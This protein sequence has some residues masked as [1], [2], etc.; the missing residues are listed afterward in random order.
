M[1]FS[2][3]RD[4]TVVLPSSETALSDELTLTDSPGGRVIIKDIQQDSPVARVG[5]LKKGDQLNAVTIHFDNLNSKEVGEILKY[6]EPYKT[7]LKLNTNDELRT[8]AYGYKRSYMGSNDQTYL[9]LY[10]SKIKPHLKLA[11]PSLEARSLI[12]NGMAPSIDG[13]S[14]KISSEFDTNL[15]AS[16]TIGLNT[17]SFDIN[18]PHG[19]IQMPDVKAS[20]PNV[21]SPRGAIKMPGMDFKGAGFEMPSAHL[22]GIESTS[23]KGGFDGN[24]PS[25]ELHAPKF[26]M[27]SPDLHGPN[28]SALDT[29]LNFKAPNVKD[30][31]LN[32]SSPNID[33]EAPNFQTSNIDVSA[34]KVGAGIRIPKFKKPAFSLTGNDPKGPELDLSIPGVKTDIKTPDMDLNGGVDL[35]DATGNWKMPKMPSFGL[36]GPKGPDVEF[37][38][39]LKAPG[40]QIDLSAPDIKGDIKGP[41]LDLKGPN[42]DINAPRVN[43]PDA[44]GTLK[45]PNIKMPSFGFSGPKGPG[46]DFDG[47]VKAP[48]VDV[49]SPNIKGNFQSPDI[50]L[51]LPKGELDANLPDAE[52]NG[53]KFKLPGVKW[54][55]NKLSLSGPDNGLKLPKGHV[56]LSAP[57]LTGDIKGPSLGLKGPNVDLNAPSVGIPD[58]KTKFKMPSLPMTSFGMSGPKV[59]DLNVDGSVKAPSIDMSA[60]NIKGNFESS[61]VDIKLPKGDLDINMPYGDIKKPKFKM[62]KFNMP[63]TNMSIPDTSL[64]LKAPTV[65]GDFDAKLKKPNLD[66]S[67]IKGPDM[68]LGGNLKIPDADISSPDLKAGFGSAGIGFQK[69]KIKADYDMPDM[70]LD[71]PDVKLKGKGIKKPS[72]NMSAGKISVPDG[73]LNLAAPNV[74]LA[75]PKLQGDFKGPNI[76]IKSPKIDGSGAEGKF[77]FPKF[78]KPNFTL[79]RKKPKLD[80]SVPNV[81]ADIK[82]P[83]VD[84][85]GG[86]DLPEAKGKWKAPS[87]HL[88][89]FGGFGPK[90]PDGDFD[91]SFKAPGVD[92]SAPNLKGNFESPDI[93]LKLPK[94]E[95]DTNLPDA[96]LN[97]GKFK[98]PGVKWPHNKLSLSGPDKDLK[99]PKGQID[100]SAPDIRGGIKG[101]GLDV[102]GPNIDLNAP[103]IDVPDAKARFKMPN[104]HMPSF[105]LAGPKAPG[106][107]G[108]VK[109][110]DIDVSGPKIKGNFEPPNV[111]LNIPKGDLDINMPSAEIKKPKFTMPNFSMPSAN[112]STPDTSL[113]LKAPVVTGDFDAKLNKPNLDIPRI[114]GPDM[115]FGGNLKIPDADVKAGFGTAG[116]DFKKPK[117]N[118]DYDMPDMNLDV[119]DV[120]LKGKG[121]KKPS[122]NMSAGKISAPDVDLNLAAPNVDLASPKLQ[123]DFKGPNIDLNAPK[124]DGIDADGNFKLPKLT[125]PA[126]SLSGNKPKVPDLNLSVPDVKADI[127]TP[128]MDLNGGVDL[129]EAKGKWKMPKL[130][131]PSFGVSGPKG[132]DVDFDGSIKTPG[133][134]VSAP[135]LKGNFDSPDVDLKFP[136]GK[137]DANLPETELTGGKFKLPGVNW[138][139]SKLSLSGP[140][141]ELNLPKGQVDFSAPDIKGDIKGPGLDLKGPNMDINAPS[142]NMPDA[143]GK[144][145]MPNLTMPSFGFSGPKGPGVDFDGSVKAPSVDVSAPNLKGNFESPNVDLKLPKGKI[146]ANLP[147]AELK[148]GKFKLPGVNWP[149]NKLPLSGPDN[150]L[151]LP[152]GQVDLSGPDIQGDIRGPSIDVKAPHLSVS[153]P[154]SK[155]QMPKVELPSIRMSGPKTPDLGVNSSVKMPSVDVAGPSIKGNYKSPDFGIDVPNVSPGNV[156]L[157][158]PTGNIKGGAGIDM[159]GLNKRNMQGANIGVK[160]TKFSVS[161]PNLNGG[162]REVGVDVNSPNPSAQLYSPK[163]KVSTD[164]NINMQNNFSRE[165]F[166]LRSSSASDLDDVTAQGK[167]NTN[168]QPR[169]SSSIN[170]NDPSVSKKNKFKLS[171]LF[172]FNHKSK[173]SVDFTKSQA[174]KSPGTFQPNSLF[175]QVEFAVSK[176]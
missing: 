6:T 111:D 55:A 125:K 86:V 72:L 135:N 144:F 35:P 103:S 61:D 42:M 104:L 116:I 81:K 175:P 56:D 109:V 34:P 127:K 71:V 90:G 156:D 165:T 89:S 96:E 102:K 26:Q 43:M 16:P 151:N 49:S 23:P 7:S 115:N 50:D 10:N 93:D 73:N 152:N 98:L 153:E 114:K 174:A 94:G 120:K 53:G 92:V 88:P 163:L 59:P 143:N 15:K 9:K 122:L 51:K 95:L 57:N 170:V 123:G 32:L 77:K 167:Y 39:S 33:L 101:P 133:I 4:T 132:P 37:D 74:D 38:G 154:K 54:P 126:F 31:G 41:S 129:P 130:H 140:E 11:K 105:G 134:D 47:S 29:N 141:K 60:P 18:G 27:S 68:N 87:L 117:I 63:S 150:G 24:L 138:P 113:N 171:K 3:H 66:I 139:S 145:K 121:I 14:P 108:S 83:D 162:F 62:P 107:D 76:D 19:K 124:V 78:K 17:P 79:N 85:D 58:A 28:V 36:S 84:L 100:L 142:V 5:T 128:D 69:P 30:V 82:S 119:P 176:D 70:N 25:A 137:I 21:E 106:L 159:S 136:K 8:P 1:N 40:G 48:S 44:N 168:L 65:T 149:G 148:G 169:T 173:G 155:F 131:L 80:V 112:L 164:E 99:L 146:D 157:N 22:S 110:P 64:N 91:G 45:M 20:T 172:N 97:G 75:A 166:K 160:D 67:G 147:E 158:L 2:M 118:A 13:R 161:S 46:V 12:V 52:L